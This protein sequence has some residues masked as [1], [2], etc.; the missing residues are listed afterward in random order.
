MFVGQFSSIGSVQAQSSVN[1]PTKTQDTRAANVNKCQSNK[2]GKTPWNCLFLDE[3]IG[4]RPGYDLYIQTCITDKAGVRKCTTSL[5]NGGVV[6][7]GARGPM[8][9]LLTSDPSKPN[10]GPFGLLYSY[11]DNVYTFASGLI[12]GIAVLFIVL[13]GIE[14]ITSAGGEGFNN[15]KKRITQALTGLVLWFLA[16]L[17]LYTINP[18]FF[19][20]SPNV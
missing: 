10:Q 18:T 19:S 5:W 9:A 12:V 11:L 17:I 6:P 13:G 16:S 1:S 20:F 7:E 3:P 14:M 4:G 15:G 2:E 8:Q